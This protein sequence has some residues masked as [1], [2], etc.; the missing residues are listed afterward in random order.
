MVT[1]ILNHYFITLTLFMTMLVLSF[2]FVKQF[3]NGFQLLITLTI[4]L[5]LVNFIM[6]TWLMKAH[7]SMRKVR[8]IQTLAFPCSIIL[9]VLTCFFMLL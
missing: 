5:T 3:D 9:I 8:L 1:K 6:E 7:L 4:L 2:G